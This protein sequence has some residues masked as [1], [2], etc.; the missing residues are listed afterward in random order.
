[1]RRGL[2]ALLLLAAACAARDPAPRAGGASGETPELAV[3]AS[4]GGVRFPDLPPDTSSF[5]PFASWSE[6]N[7]ANIGGEA[8][9]FE[10]F[11]DPYTWFL[12][13]QSASERVL[14]GEPAEPGAGDPP[15]A[16]AALELRDGQWSPRGWGQ[17]RIEL[18]ADGWG[19]A[20]LRLDPAIRPDPQSRTVSVLAREVACAGGQAPQGREVRAIVL[21][22]TDE[23]VSILMLVEP[24][25]G[26]QTCPGNPSFEFQADLGSPLGDRKILDASVYPPL[27]REWSPGEEPD[28]A[29]VGIY[30]ALI[31][32]LVNP[33]GTQPIYVISDL[34]YQLMK[35]KITC[36]DH[37]S[38]GE[39]QELLTRLQDLGDVVFLSNDESGPSPDEPFQEIVLGPIVET[40]DGLRVEGGSI[41]GGVC[42]NGAVYVVVATESGYRVTGTDETYGA[43]VA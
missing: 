36:P 17:C 22:E 20:R 9:F 16:Y 23:A 11:V 25:T 18:E 4:C 34:C 31:R 40:A 43:W 3:F 32:H 7:L 30:E 6:V 8:P 10:E 37:F 41:C 39:R 1:M 15:Y 24:P 29:R 14:F 38:R 27:E 26:G 21:D 12:A 2:V 42:G 13:D 19:N 35:D 5:V 28:F 33:D